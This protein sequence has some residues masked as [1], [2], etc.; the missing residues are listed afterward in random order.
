[1]LYT[2]QIMRIDNQSLILFQIA[3]THSFFE[4][5]LAT[6]SHYGVD[7]FHGKSFNK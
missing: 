7:Q 6:T 3:G 5:S 1:M 4:I 2:L